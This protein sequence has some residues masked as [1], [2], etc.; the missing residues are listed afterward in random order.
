M[1]L[2]SIF[3]ASTWSNIK[4]KDSFEILRTSRFQ[5]WPYFLN[6]VKIWGS[7]CQKTKKKK[8]LDPPFIIALYIMSADLYS[9]LTIGLGMK[10]YPKLTPHMHQ[11]IQWFKSYGD[12]LQCQLICSHFFIEWDGE[13]GFLPYQLIYIVRSRFTIIFTWRLMRGRTDL[14]SW[15]LWGCSFLEYEFDTIALKCTLLNFDFP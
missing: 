2:T 11:S 15:Q 9:N 6:L 5:N 10:N 13:Q 3:S 12:L 7:Y 1:S 14:Y 4:S 8:F